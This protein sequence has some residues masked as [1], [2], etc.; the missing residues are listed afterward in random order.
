MPG[1][2]SI[3]FAVC[4]SAQALGAVSEPL[5]GVKL[6]RTGAA[7]LSVVDLCAPGVSMRTT[8]YSERRGTVATWATKAE[9][10]AQI[11]IN[12]DFF[13]NGVWS[14]VIGRSRGAGED[15]P[16]S[17]QHREQR[18]Y[19]QFGPRIADLQRD[20][21]N[22]PMAGVTEIVGSHN[23]LISEGRSLGPNFDGDGVLMS[24]ARRTAVGISQDRKTLFL[25]V[26]NDALT[27]SG[28]VSQMTALVQ[29]AGASPI[30]FATN[31][32]GGGSTQMYVQGP[33]TVISSSREVNNHIGVRATGSGPSPQC[34][35]SDWEAQWMA[36][37]FPQGMRMR[38][39]AGTEI[40]GWVELKNTGMKPWPAG[41]T[42][43]GTTEPRD[44]P[45]MLAAS[46]WPSATRMATL[47]ADVA[48]GGTGRFTFKLKA[49][50]TPGAHFQ[51]FGVVVEG[52]AWLGDSGGPRDEQLWVEVTSEG[53]PVPKLGAQL[54]EDWPGGRAGTLRPGSTLTGHFSFKNTGSEVWTPAKTFLATRDET[55]SPLAGADWVSPARAA[56]VD[57]DVPPGGVGVFTFTVAAPQQPGVY[58]QAFALLQDGAGWFPRSEEL[59]LEATV[60]ASVEKRSEWTGLEAQDVTGSCASV[61]AG[62][63]WPGLAALSFA[64]LRR[65]MRAG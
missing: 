64:L 54:S 47:S 8:R 11:A 24:G 28:I 21:A 53:S 5:P 60:D 17:A 33:G 42:S 40:E 1:L 12:G 55:V 48:P 2:R 56:A 63:L 50:E 30:W 10:N 23:I 9:V 45:S 32:D 62:L 36:D 3:L 15:W 16:A 29:E 58:R 44:G 52:V 41:K 27:G 7:A 19:W 20:S 49:P 57:R 31:M 65:R 22:A 35:G 18:Q 13:D 39:P 61:P 26:S 25:F 6:V 34:P 51:F 38:A 59:W 43:L 4:L 14:W 46:G 37:G